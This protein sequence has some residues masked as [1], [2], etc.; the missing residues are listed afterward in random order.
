LV[1]WLPTT[2]SRE[3]TRFRRLQEECDMALESSQRELQDYFKPHPNPRF[4]QEVMDTQSPGRPTRD[5]FGTPPWESR[6]KVP[7]ECSPR[8]ELQRILYRG[9]WWLPPSLGRGELS[10]SKVARGLFQ[11]QKGAE[12]VITNLW[13]VLDIGLCNKI[14]VPLPSLIMGLLARPLTPFNAGSRERHQVPTPSAFPH[15]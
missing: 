15:S 10:E 9:R 6:E 5:S 14:I 1:V 13:L 7:F 11:H 2:K 3:S 8:G 4:E 12:W